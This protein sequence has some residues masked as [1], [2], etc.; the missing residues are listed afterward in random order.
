MVGTQVSSKPSNVLLST[1]GLRVIDF[2]VARPLDAVVDITSNGQVVGTPR[3]T[4]PELL[5]GEPVTAACDVFAWG[6]LVVFAAS[7]R[8]PFEGD[9][10]AIHH[11]IL[12]VEPQL[13]FLQSDLREPV[14]AA[15]TKVPGLRPASQQLLDHL[16]GRSDSDLTQLRAV[17][18]MTKPTAEGPPPGT[19][20]LLLLEA[21][22]D[23][24]AAL[25]PPE[26]GR[27][28][29][30]YWKGGR[31]RGLAI[32]GGVGI[33]LASLLSLLAFFSSGPPLDL[34]VLFHDDFEQPG[35]GWSG[36][37]YHL[38]STDWGYGYA[39]GGFYAIDVSGSVSSGVTNVAPIPGM[40]LRSSKSSQPSAG[41]R[42][43][44][45]IA[46]F[47]DLSTRQ[48]TSGRGTY[49]VFCRGDLSSKPI[50]Y[51][52]LLDEAGGAR[53]R[54]VQD[55]ASWDLAHVRVGTAAKGG[56]R[57]LAA[58]CSE[59]SG[60]IRLTMWLDGEYVQSVTDAV[61]RPNGVSGIV[62]NTPDRASVMRVSFDDFHVSGTFRAKA[63]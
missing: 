25:S 22:T 36:G 51:E 58:E 56:S 43:P 3:Y 6:C 53:I 7:G 16:V 47:V 50:R 42:L 57:R 52:F 32:A 40:A 27:R 30:I 45:R 34:P 61:P 29:M 31:K 23:D 54:R 12:H 44:E 15:L 14:R 17:S 1:G 63:A 18:L 2:G 39:P 26:E 38:D 48:G 41:E 60:G 59:E 10:P 5:R 24:D 55:G 37:N 35:S 62:A 19:E 49:G 11:Q 4:A 8:P 20:T 9:I 28:R 21:P 33:A 13:D 46:I